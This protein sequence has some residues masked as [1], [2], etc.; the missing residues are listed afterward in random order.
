M[1]RMTAD[2][3]SVYQF[4]A[5]LFR[6]FAFSLQTQR[7]HGKQRASAVLSAAEP[8]DLRKH[9]LA[10]LPS[11]LLCSAIEKIPSDDKNRQRGFG[12]EKRI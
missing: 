7:T 1:F 9:T 12:A 6:A 2:Y 5:H 8:V 10:C 3:Y 11:N 4:I